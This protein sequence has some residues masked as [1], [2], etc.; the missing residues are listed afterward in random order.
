MSNFIR[1]FL[2]SVKLE[3]P[4]RID[5]RKRKAPPG[6]QKVERLV[7]A[8]RRDTLSEVTLTFNEN[9][10]KCSCKESFAVSFT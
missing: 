9:N 10:V 3:I 5:R 7:K 1:S 4:R 6:L 2:L 8:N